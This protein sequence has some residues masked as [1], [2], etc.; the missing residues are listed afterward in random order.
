[1]GPIGITASYVKKSKREEAVQAWSRW[2][3]C[4]RCG[5]QTIKTANPRGFV[6]TAAEEAAHAARVQASTRD[7]PQVGSMVKID[8]FPYNGEI[9]TIIKLSNKDCTVE[10]NGGRGKAR[11]IDLRKIELI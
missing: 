9:G 2:G 8:Q 6:P 5:S 10:L 7:S 4:A 11:S 3:V 1:M